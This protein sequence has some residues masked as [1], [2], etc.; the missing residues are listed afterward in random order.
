MNCY[1]KLKDVNKLTE[2]IKRDENKSKLN[3]EVETAI[4][5]CRQA[6][7][8][9]H[10]LYLAQRHN[11]HEWYLKILLENL[12][13]YAQAILYISSLSFF[14]AEKNLKK[15]GKTLINSIPEQT[16]K[17]LMELCTN[18]NPS[19]FE[20]SFS[21]LETKTEENSNISRSTS[22]GTSLNI[23]PKNSGNSNLKANPD[24]FIHIFVNQEE[25]LI[26][27]LEFIIQKTEASHL[28]YNTLLELYLRPANSSNPISSIHT[29]EE[30]DF[31]NTKEL[32]I[33]KEKR[34][35]KAMEILVSNKYDA[36]HA[37]VLCQTHDFKIGVLYLYE[38]M[39]LYQEIM[40]YYM[41]NNEYGQ[42]VESAKKYGKKDSYLWI[43]ALSYFAGV[44]EDCETE[45]KEVLKNI[46]EENLLPPLRVVQILSQK[47]S[48][49]L[50]VIKEYI[51]SKLQKENEHIDE[52]KR[53][54]NKLK[55]ETKKMAEEIE[56]LKTTAKIFQH[57]KCAN[58]SSLLDI[59]AVHFLCSHSFHH[60]CLFDNDTECP[61]CAPQTK[62]IL[63]LIHSHEQSANDHEQFFKKLQGF[64]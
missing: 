33:Q 37:L 35:K 53:E 3:F 25:W 13:D 34:Q 56:E 29:L 30:E 22:T 54:I 42:V 24:E 57:N 39:Q 28:I 43:E 41:Q 17:L 40:K 11:E 63:E 49:T 51:I 50:S 58:C 55:E 64:Y 21:N 45:I 38:K 44:E 31:S 46:D 2:F 32:E 26:N 20:D 6:G 9:E 52:D 48:C 36:D 10:A 14:E 61:K 1:T 59:P 18:Y 12:K 23:K 4:K 16:T 60:R 62:H 7:Y 5:V 47:K 8:N 27:F 15:Y 19:V